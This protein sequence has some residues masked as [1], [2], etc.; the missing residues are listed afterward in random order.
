MTNE[1]TAIDD[2]FAGPG[3]WDTGLRMIGR[4]DVTGIEWDAVACATARAAGHRRV[5]ADVSAL[6][7][8]DFRRGRP[9]GQIASP[10]CQGFS[11][12]GLGKGRGDAGRIVEAVRAIGLGV[13]ADF[14][15][16]DLAGH[17]A[18]HRSA[19]VLEPLRW[20][21]A[22][23]PEWLAWEQV[24]PVLPLW[25]ACAEVLRSHGWNVWTGNVQAE[26]Y[27]V[28][29]TRRRAILLAHRSRPVGRPAPT[30]SR[31]HSADP[32]RLDPG[33]PRWVSM[34]EAL[35]W[36]MTDRPS[37]TVTGGGSS[38]GG[39]EPFGN[40][41][42]RGMLR[43]LDAGHWAQ[44][45]NYSAHGQGRTAA[46]R[47]RTMRTLDEPSVTLTAK[48]PQWQYVGG[49]QSNATVRDIDEPAPT[50]YSQRS[51]NARWVYR[52][53]NQ[54]HAARRPLSTPAPTV[55]FSERIPEDAASDRSASGVRVTV[56]E[57]AVLQTFPADYP[58]AGTK[59]DQYRQVGDAVP[60]LL[61]AHLLAS[62]GVGDLR[63][64]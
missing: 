25:V 5:Q 55:N 54:D 11:P 8:A 42:R 58:F 17:C 21:L 63:R 50:V 2:L 16:Y 28:P 15:V 47:G 31:Y 61:A 62:L 49:P 1:E 29:Q 23:E 12:A 39:A 26:Q 34:A 64:A 46:E 13:P 20:A 48:P 36:G 9:E 44:R 4:T 45:S 18:D 60:P 32:A 56:A 53:S 57:A 27:G 3:G 14:V 7:P 37:M 40:A 22:T 41:A 51:G 38:T 33:L 43:E 19:L 24:A 59:G 10:P 52:A 30:H 6:R 35:G